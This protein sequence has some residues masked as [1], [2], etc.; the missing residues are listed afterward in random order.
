MDKLNG[1]E[2]VETKKE[3]EVVEDVTGEFEFPQIREVID[4]LVE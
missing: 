4:A 1:I 2:T 3:E